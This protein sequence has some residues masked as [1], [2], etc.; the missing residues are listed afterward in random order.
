MFTIIKCNQYVIVTLIGNMS[1]CNWN[2]MSSTLNTIVDFHRR[3]FQNIQLA[4]TFN[5][6]DCHSPSLELLSS[7]KLRACLISS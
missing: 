4:V 7:F 3:I 1:S 6:I 2:N 5:Y